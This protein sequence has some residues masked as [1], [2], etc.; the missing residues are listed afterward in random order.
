MSIKKVLITGGAGF[1]G[2]HLAKAFMRRDIEV[3]IYDAFLSYVPKGESLY[4]YYLE[5]RLNEIKCNARII[6]GDIR[7]L[8]MVHKTIK[9]TRP[10]VVIHLA[11]IPIANPSNW[12]A[13]DFI[14]T[15]LNGT[16]NVLDCIR[17]E[18]S[19]K[20]FIYASSSYVYGNFLYEPANEEHPVSPVDI[21]GGTKLS[22]EIITKT[23]QKECGIEY[24]IIR[25]SAVYGPTD[26]NMRVSQILMD[27]AMSGSPLILHNKG[28]DRIDFT[29]VKDTVQGF[30]LAAFSDKARNE[31]FNITRGEGKSIKEFS[32]ILKKFFPRIRCI[33]SSRRFRKPIRGSL[34]ISKAKDLLGYE[35]QYGLDEGIAEY[36][37]FLKGKRL[38]KLKENYVYTTY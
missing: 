23:F 2:Y 18:G 8:E 22:G 3:I 14:L 29:Y 37:N 35:P 6:R 30:I 19:V 9:D 31:T 25:P 21:Y 10:E 7:H 33:E 13:E 36:A 28:A 38:K 16:F 11:A 5:H 27:N 15:N 24:T 20:R 34:D 1:I 4:S 26:A 17:K 12:L 32:E